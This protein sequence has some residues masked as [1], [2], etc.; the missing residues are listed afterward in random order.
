MTKLYIDISNND[1]TDLILVTEMLKNC[2]IQNIYL[3]FEYNEIT[4]VAGLNTSFN[5]LTGVNN[6]NLHL[7]YF[8][9]F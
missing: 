5:N 2:S 3:H 9:F 8:I 4:D 6:F 7:K 1:L